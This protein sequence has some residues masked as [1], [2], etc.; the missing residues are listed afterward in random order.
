MK[1]HPSS[2]RILPSTNKLWKGDHNRC[3]ACLL[4][5]RFGE[6][7]LDFRHF[8][9]DLL[10]MYRKSFRLIAEGDAGRSKFHIVRLKLIGAC[11]EDAISGSNL[12]ICR[13]IAES[14]LLT[15][16]PYV[17][18]AVVAG[19]IAGCGLLHVRFDRG[20]PGAGRSALIISSSLPMPH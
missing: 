7:G 3:H 11:V 8:I 5:L 12:L 16:F 2:L 6:V 9:D 18:V 13:R 10:R 15:L 14:V 1:I 20:A 4:C 17:P 19:W